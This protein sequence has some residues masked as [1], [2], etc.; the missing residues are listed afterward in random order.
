VTARRSQSLYHAAVHSHRAAANA[1]K[2][3]HKYN[4][5]IRVVVITISSQN[6]QIQ[7]TKT[8]QTHNTQQTIGHEPLYSAHNVIP[9]D[10]KPIAIKRGVI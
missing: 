4:A 1:I 10:G 8:N 9:V 7:K 3:Q 5:Y 2:H 6:I